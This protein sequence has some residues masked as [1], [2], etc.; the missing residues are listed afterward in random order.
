MASIKLSM[1]KEA[2]YT[3]EFDNN[4]FSY[5]DMIVKVAPY[6]IR[7]GGRKPS[8][9]GDETAFITDYQGQSLSLNLSD[10]DVMNAMVYGS[11]NVDYI[12]KVLASVL[13]TRIVDETGHVVGNPRK[14][15]Q[16]PSEPPKR[17]EGV[18][19]IDSDSDD[20]IGVYDQAGSWTQSTP[21][22]YMERLL[23]KTHQLIDEGYDE[24][25]AISIAINRKEYGGGS[26]QDADALRYLLKQTEGSK[27]S[28]RL[29]KEGS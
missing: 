29:T 28:I 19:R 10:G 27:A 9:R 23:R 1:R 13:G 25:E 8:G 6:G 3:I 16:P 24:D 18:S 4:Y 2:S 17:E 22:E 12:C 26:R 20:Y 14:Q 11:A 7:R 21:R 5:A 15:M